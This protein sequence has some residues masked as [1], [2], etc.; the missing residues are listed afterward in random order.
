MD[1]RYQHHNSR[2]PYW[3]ERL[4][5]WALCRM[6]AELSASFQAK[7]LKCERNEQARGPKL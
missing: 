7:L 5:D 2:G 1:I 3:G 4:R 6:L